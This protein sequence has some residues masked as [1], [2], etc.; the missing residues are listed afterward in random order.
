MYG[1]EILTLAKARFQQ[2]LK[3][4]GI[5][6]KSLT[7]PLVSRKKYLKT[8]EIVHNRFCAKTLLLPFCEGIFGSNFEEKIIFCHILKIMTIEIEVIKSDYQPKNLT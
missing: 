7:A 5:S 3:N 6:T 2:K 8:V 1:A 4:S